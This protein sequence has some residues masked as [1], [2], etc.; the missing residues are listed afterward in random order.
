M[1]GR[2]VV[3]RLV[4]LLAVL[5][6]SSFLT[7]MLTSLTPGDPT[8]AILGKDRPQEQYD[9]LRAEL[10]LDGPSWA[11]TGRWSRGTPRGSA[12]PSTATSVPRSAPAARRCRPGWRRRCR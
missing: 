9:E 3:R 1:G 4:E 10:G 5:L 12:T 6:L 8:I 7:F 11:S 2:Q